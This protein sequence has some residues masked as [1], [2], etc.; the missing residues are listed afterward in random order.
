MEID[1]DT[2]KYAALSGLVTPEAR[3]KLIDNKP[4]IMEILRRYIPLWQ[5]T[6]NAEKS[7]RDR[8][9]RLD[10]CCDRKKLEEDLDLAKH[11]ARPGW[12]D[13]EINRRQFENEG[14]DVYLEVKTPYRISVSIEI[15]PVVSDDYPKVLR[16]M[17]AARVDR[18]WDY[19]VLF[20]ERYTGQGA[21]REQ[22]IQTFKSANIRVIFRDE[23]S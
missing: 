6:E 2:L 23:V 19:H 4:E 12:M 5:Q 21:T 9:R 3:Q 20:L 13:F 7:Y 18:T 14:I 8:A 16:Q 15:K 11:K 1:G 17:R 10:W 22:F